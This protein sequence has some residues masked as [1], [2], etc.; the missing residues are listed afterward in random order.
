MAPPMRRESYTGAGCYH[1][2]SDGLR[3][4]NLRAHKT[5]LIAA[6]A[7][8]HSVPLENLE[9]HFFVSFYEKSASAVTTP[10]LR[11][12]QGDLQPLLRICAP[13]LNSAFTMLLQ[14]FYEALAK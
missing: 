5:L 3:S 12:K 1:I 4:K 9:V 11:F 2:R 10:L 8:R 7:E 6:E 13:R 14:G